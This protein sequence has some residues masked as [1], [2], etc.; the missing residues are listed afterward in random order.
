MRTG[1][2]EKIKLVESHAAV[3]FYNIRLLASASRI[4]GTPANLLFN[5]CCGK[6]ANI[7]AMVPQS[8]IAQPFK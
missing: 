5:T 4:I 2:T 8:I 6:S 1:S 3:A 7:R